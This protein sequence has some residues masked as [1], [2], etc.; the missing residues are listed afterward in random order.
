MK[1]RYT[2]CTGTQ[3]KIKVT[4]ELTFA[5][6]QTAAAKAGLPTPSDSVIQGIQR[7]SRFAQL[8]PESAA[9]AQ[10]RQHVTHGYTV[11]ALRVEH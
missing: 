4:Y 1:N 8:Y 10:I 5:G 3:P 11:V 2:D 6:A 9:A 7:R